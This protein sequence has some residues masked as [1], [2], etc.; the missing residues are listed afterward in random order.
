MR[1]REGGRERRERERGGGREETWERLRGLH[2]GQKWRA[3]TLYGYN[4]H[5][6]HS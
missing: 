5:Y 4:Y 1:E 2:V 6:T 3:N